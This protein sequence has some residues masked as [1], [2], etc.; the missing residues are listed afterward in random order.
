MDRLKKKVVKISIAVICITCLSGCFD[1]RELDTMGIVMGVAIDKAE[2]EG[3]TELTV[4]MANPAGES[5][6]GSKGKES[7]EK[8]GGKSPAFVN[9][10]STGRNINYIVRQ[11]QRKMS[12]MIYVAHNQAIVFGEELA[13]SG[14]RDAL[15]FF[16]R[17]PEARMTLNVFVAKGKAKDILGIEPEFEKVTSTELIK[18]L[19]DQKIT[20]HAPIV[21]E[22]EFVSTMVS[23]TTAAVA[24][25]VRII[26][27]D[28]TDR[29]SVS[30]CAVFKDSIMVGELSEVETRGLLFVKNKV[31]TGVFELKILNTPATIEIRKS[32]TKTQPVLYTDGRVMFN[33]DVNMTVGLGDQSGDLNLAAP[34]NSHAMLSAVESAVKDEIKSA[35]EKSKE[36]NADVFGFGEHLNRKYPDQWRD[37]R[38]RWDEIYKNI[39]VNTTVKVK[40]DG[41]GRIDRPLVP[42]QA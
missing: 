39:T 38:E 25:I 10:T 7:M 18:I 29:L 16:A 4:Q 23:K 21:T 27:E 1:R 14:V 6:S 28:E 41:G 32:R 9:V 12:R 22:F 20:S 26:N 19:R 35:V 11:M 33:V 13:E 42:E 30:G 3:E 24:P 8:E 17:A 2:S 5:A 36:L 37:M 15:D 31:K 40:A 34:E